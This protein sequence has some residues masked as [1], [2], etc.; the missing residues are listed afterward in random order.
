M[1]KIRIP[2]GIALVIGVAMLIWG[3]RLHKPVA[4]STDA[5]F[6][7]AN[8]LMVGGVLIAMIACFAIGR[9]SKT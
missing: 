6:I 2:S 4:E 7:L 5:G 9:S 3:Q 8:G 1:S